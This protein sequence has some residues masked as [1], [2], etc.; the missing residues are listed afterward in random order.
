MEKQ[1]LENKDLQQAYRNIHDFFDW[2]DFASAIKETER[3]IMAAA[4]TK[5]WFRDYPYR[6]IGF[7][8][9]LQELVAA[10]F[11]IK[12]DYFSRPACVLYTTSGIP[13]L[14]LTQNFVDH[15]SSSTTWNNV[16]RHLTAI[17][18]ADP[19]IVIEKFICY[20]TE[21]EWK[22][23]CNYLAEYALC[24]ESVDAQYSCF[25]LLTIRLHLLRLIEACHLLEVRA[26]KKTKRSKKK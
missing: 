17:Q 16:P 6:S 25:E 13:D 14:A 8:N 18:Y 24:N 4:R 5:F 26:N 1:T 11:L 22:Q 3:I 7:M 9:K 12:Q 19:Y 10:A 20:A 23:T 2:Y 21:P 15:Y